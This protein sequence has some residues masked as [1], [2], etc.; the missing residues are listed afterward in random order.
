M[1]WVSEKSLREAFS[2]LRGTDHRRAPGFET[3]LNRLGESS[4]ERVPTHDAEALAV[5]DLEALRS[6]SPEDRRLRQARRKARRD[7]RSLLEHPVETRR[8]T[9]ENAR[10]RYRSPAFVE[11][12]VEE[13]RRL[14]R[15]DPRA[16]EGLAAL[17]PVAIHWMTGEV[18]PTWAI[19]LRALAMAQEANALRVAGSLAAADRR[20]ADLRCHLTDHPPLC[21]ADL[22][23]LASLEASLRYDQRRY[24][25]ASR[26][27]DRAIFHYRLAQDS[28]GMARVL[29]QKGH[30]DFDEGRLDEAQAAYS[31]GLSLLDPE[32]D[33]F[34]VQ[35]SVTGQV[36]TFCELEAFETAAALLEAHRGLYADRDLYTSAVARGLE[37][38]IAMGRGQWEVAESAFSD[39]RD[40][41]L[42]VGREHD[43][44]LACLDLAHSLLEQGKSSQVTLMAAEI[45]EIFRARGTDP[46]TLS[47]LLLIHRAAASQT[48]TK[49]LLTKTYRRLKAQ[50]P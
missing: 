26:L 1:S 34:L 15:H 7:L 48:L 8:S 44:T 14:V 16:A 40:S 42:A 45:L 10:T 11:I 21:S 43:A 39:C 49:A 20:F 19:Q 46:E 28:Q 31:H 6:L 5:R 2:V 13:S 4:E 23:Q 12:L 36:N 9:I 29:I 50:R 47:A 25:E 24:P 3:V 22:G 17:V 35:A 33:S 32:I 18:D 30:L 27:L 41:Y 38:R 37:G